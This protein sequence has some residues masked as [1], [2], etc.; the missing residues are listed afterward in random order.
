MPIGK[1]PEALTTPPGRVNLD[2]YSAECTRQDNL[3]QI[4]AGG[5]GGAL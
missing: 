1:R 4:V 3:F 5:P 2:C